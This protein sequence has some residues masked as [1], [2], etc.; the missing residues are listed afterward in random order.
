MEVA[1]TAKRN[2]DREC[3]K[4]FATK[5]ALLGPR[6]MSDL[7]PQSG[8]QRTLSRH[9]RMTGSD[10]NDMPPNLF[11]DHP[12]RR[13]AWRRRRRRDC[14]CDPRIPTVGTALKPQ[15]RFDAA[16]INAA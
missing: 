9:R 11:R 2:F 4:T 15:R 5:S 12:P 8:P 14:E 6:E 13:R 10:S 1:C 7:S 3:K 16:H